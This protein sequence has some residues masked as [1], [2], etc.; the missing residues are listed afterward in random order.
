MEFI[1]NIKD[2]KRTYFTHFYTLLDLDKNPENTPVKKKEARDYLYEE[3]KIN[4]RTNVEK[5]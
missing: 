4:A 1:S 2:E 3:L 5:I